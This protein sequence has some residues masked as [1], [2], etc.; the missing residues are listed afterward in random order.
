MV[1]VVGVGVRQDRLVGHGIQE[2]EAQDRGARAPARGGGARRHR[3]FVDPERI[4]ERRWD[5]LLHD[6]PTLIG[7]LVATTLGRAGDVRTVPRTARQERR[8]V[9]LAL[10]AETAGR[11]LFVTLAA[12]GGV[13]QRYEAGLRGELPLEHFLAAIEPG[14]FGA[15]QPGQG[16]AGL[17]RRGGARPRGAPPPGGAGAPARAHT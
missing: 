11:R 6:R 8:R 9:H 1:T 5:V 7:E 17:R 15:L 3:L 2:T 14:P 4:M 10:V 16:V 13:E 12:R